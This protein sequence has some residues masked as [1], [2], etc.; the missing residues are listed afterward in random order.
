MI[1]VI[2]RAIIVLEIVINP[3][4]SFQSCAL[5]FIKILQRPAMQARVYF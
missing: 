3:R 5:L 2:S 4:G 1:R